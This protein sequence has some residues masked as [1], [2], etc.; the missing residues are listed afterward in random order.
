MNEGVGHLSLKATTYGSG[1]WTASNSRY[2][3]L[4]T[5]TAHAGPHR[6]HDVCVHT[7]MRE[8]NDRGFEGGV[9]GTVSNS[10]TLIQSLV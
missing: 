8:A 1:V 5:E 9:F 10:D 4:R 6:H 2:S 3:P 7:S